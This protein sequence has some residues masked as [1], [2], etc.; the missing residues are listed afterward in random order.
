M[1]TQSIHTHTNEDLEFNLTTKVLRNMYGAVKT[2]ALPYILKHMD[3][4][5]I[6]NK[7]RMASFL[8]SCFIMSCGFRRNA[9]KFDYCAARL[10][11][12]YPDK[13]TNIAMAKSVMRGGEQEVANLI[14]SNVGGNGNIDSNDG[15]S[16]KARSAL[17][18]RGRDNYT[19]VSDSTG[20]DCLNNPEMLESDENYIVSAMAIWQHRGLNEA[21]DQLK[22]ESSYELDAKRTNSGT[23]N[24]RSNSCAV[25]IRKKLDGNTSNL[26]DF[27]NFVEMGMLY[28]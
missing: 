17:Q 14:Y 12:E 13:V 21:A 10:A 24:Y 8:A 11:K 2:D 27:C 5:G 19:V 3:D 9:E 6:N 1:S 20:I 15:W 28:L 16:Y 26:T 18:F 25:K 4:Y 7:K 22:F 23:K